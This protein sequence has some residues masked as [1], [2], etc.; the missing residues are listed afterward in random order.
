M[1]K[2][3]SEW[4]YRVKNGKKWEIFMFLGTYY[5]SIDDRGR[6]SV[7]K[8]FRDEL[9]GV[10]IVTRGL[11]GCLFLFTREAWT[12]VEQK[13]LSVPLTRADAR[14]F[15][16]LVL[17]GAMEVALDRLGRIL[18]PKYL[19]EFA[20]L[21]SEVAILGVGERIELWAKSKWESYSQNLES[22]GE[23]V[24]ERLSELGI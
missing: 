5:H 14:S 3:V 11:D 12:K 19:S 24:A 16:R 10:A 4:M 6:I 13:I 23:E 1:P 18:L 22:K 7:P 17:S 15:A 20:N 8:K 9:G 2:T 21:T